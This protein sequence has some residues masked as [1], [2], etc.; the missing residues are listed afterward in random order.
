VAEDEHGCSDG[1]RRAHRE[2]GAVERAD[3]AEVVGRQGLEGDARL[4][5]RARAEA[6]E[7]GPFRHDRDRGAGGGDT[8]SRGDARGPPHAPPRCSRGTRAPTAHTT[9]YPIVPDHSA[10]SS[11]VISS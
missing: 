2:L 8:H 10:T 7:G 9:S 6:P 1:T 11:A 5:V 3:R 4:G